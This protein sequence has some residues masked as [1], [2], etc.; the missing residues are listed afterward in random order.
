VSLTG[1]ERKIIASLALREAETTQQG[2]AAK[3]VLSL[4]ALYAY[5]SASF[6]HRVTESERKRVRE[7]RER[8]RERGKEGDG[9]ER[10]RERK[11]REGKREGERE[12]W[13]GRSE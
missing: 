12:R 4:K 5:F 6:A 9:S 1:R 8:G 2:T 10:G 11:E 7:W 13:R 3:V